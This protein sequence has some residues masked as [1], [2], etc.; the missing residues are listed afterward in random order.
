MAIYTILNK[1]DCARIADEFGLGDLVTYAGIRNGSVNTHYLLE[2]KRGRF[3]LKV[4]EVKSEL[5]I[6]QELEL[7]LYLRKLGCPCPQPLRSKKGRYYHE[8]HGKHVSVSKFIDGVELPVEK[9]ASAHL[10]VVGHALADLHLIGRGYKKG[11][12][13]DFEVGGSKLFD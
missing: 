7:L 9:L 4:D 8:L 1:R 5:E 13:N 10:E 11:M 12:A 3:F 6:K 2:T